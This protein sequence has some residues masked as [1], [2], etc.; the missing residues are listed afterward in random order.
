MGLHVDEMIRNM[1]R[2][3]RKILKNSMLNNKTVEVSLNQNRKIYN[4]WAQVR[5]SS[6]LIKYYDDIREGL[7]RDVDDMDFARNIISFLNKP[8][9]SD[10]TLVNHENVVLTAAA[11]W[12]LDA[13][14]MNGK[15]EEAVKFLPDSIEDMKDIEMVSFDHPSYDHY[16]IKGM[17]YVIKNRDEGL[18]SE[19][20]IACDI[21]NQKNKNL[22]IK[23]LE[24]EYPAR[25]RYE[26]VVNLI[27]SSYIEKVLKKFS[28]DISDVL[29]L[30]FNLR[31]SVYS[32]ISDAEKD[33]RYSEDNKGTVSVNQI[34]RMEKAAALRR[35]W[36][37]YVDSLISGR[38]VSSVTDENGVKLKQCEDIE[39]FNVED[40]YDTLF[41]VLYMFDRDMDLPWLFNAS[42]LVLSK[43]RNQLPFSV[44]PY[45]KNDYVM[46]KSDK[47]IYENIYS[48]FSVFE[49]MDEEMDDQKYKEMME[50][51]TNDLL[52]ISIRFSREE[53]DMDEE[54]DLDGDEEEINVSDDFYE[55]GAENLSQKIFSYTGVVYP[56][57][58]KI[59]DRNSYNDFIDK[60]NE[61]DRLSK[62]E[63]ANLLIHALSTGERVYLDSLFSDTEDVRSESDEYSD[64]D[65]IETLKKKIQDQKKQI[66]SLKR[67]LHTEARKASDLNVKY[68]EKAADEN[69]MLQELK[70]LREI[71]FNS[72]ENIEQTPEKETEAEFPVR[73]TDRKIVSFGGFESWLKTMKEYLP[74]VKFVSPDVIPNTELIRNSDEI[75]IQTNCM[76]HSPFYKIINIAKENKKIIRYFKYSSPKKCAVQLLEK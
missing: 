25:Y 40:P 22:E 21:I 19:N 56:R 41:A 7:G 13:L 32:M 23:N 4:N 5:R 10:F 52:G 70:D 75:W 68:E 31:E 48:R 69:A 36:D 64:E 2:D 29:S 55:E 57:V 11:I 63:L 12:I 34:R 76:S 18:L 66:V 50:D 51:I 6:A 74:D 58:A 30:Y 60:I 17:V 53:D 65:D 72:R 38:Q 26:S 62:R 47:S 71:V 14:S 16:L 37:T 43:A 44:M 8:V 61:D 39:K 42:Y 1:I 59:C 73:I 24:S 33:I 46:F 9:S 27:D 28:D 45:V 35:E 67:S 54:Y 20:G 3:Q 15:L 49:Y